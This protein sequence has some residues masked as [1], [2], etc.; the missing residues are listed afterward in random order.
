MVDVI[1]FDLIDDLLR[2]LQRLG[3]VR[4]DFRHFIGRFEP[5]LLGIVHA[6]DVVHVVV[7]AQADQPVMCLGIFFVHEMAIVGTDDFDTVLTCQFDKNR[8]DLFLALVNLYVCTR[9][10]RLMA[11]EFDII[12]V[13][14]EVLEPF[15][16][17]FRFME[18][19]VF[20]D[21]IEDFLG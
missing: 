13:T 19:V 12:I 10:L 1:H 6:V 2:V 18:V 5:F 21:S 4:E 7:G 3:E 8:I 11:L 15:Y 14:E 16:R 9:F 20:C 17:F